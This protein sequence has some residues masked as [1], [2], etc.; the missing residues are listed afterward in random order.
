MLQLELWPLW[1]VI[2]LFAVCT[3]IIAVAGSRLVRLADGL[4]D[5][6][7]L[8]EAIFGAVL[9]GGTTS[10]S[11]SVTSIT[12]AWRDH[13][14]LAVSNGVGGIVVQT[15]FLAVADICYRRANLEHAAASV[16]NL[17]QCALLITL[18]S[19]PLV[20]SFT[21]EVTW[22][23][24]HPMSVILVLAY[25]GGLHL[26]RQVKNQPLW[27]PLP[28]EATRE[29]IPEPHG[30]DHPT[31]RLWWS[32]GLLVGVLGLA[33]YWVAQSAITLADNTV[34][35][36]TAVGAFFT[37]TATSLPE[38]VTTV[39]AVRQG[40][41][42]LAVGGII[43]GNSFDVLFLA[44]SDVSY[45]A[46]SIYHAITDQQILIIVLG[47]LMSG[48][49]MLGLVRREKKGFATIG[50]ESLLILVVY[51]AGSAMLFAG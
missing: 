46:G 2:A 34:L 10:L 51:A 17:L 30:S 50:F 44:F 3:G 27:R 5:R 39:A 26:S 36:E 38:L 41:L 49:L 19:L 6:T 4:A 11:G 28:T 40:A 29:D 15:V 47:I 31:A 43:G 35:S 24:V 1:G 20:A 16:A 23:A 21:P 18:L 9:L 33:G 13:P 42:T 7:G 12:A 25:L 45:R 8:G 32:F 22:F 37:A 48:I 14:E